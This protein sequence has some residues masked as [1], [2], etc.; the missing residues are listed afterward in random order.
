MSNAFLAGDYLLAAEG[1]VRKRM[2]ALK[3]DSAHC[4]AV[5][6]ALDKLGVDY[7]S[8]G[9]RGTAVAHIVIPSATLA[10]WLIRT[11]NSLARRQD[12]VKEWEEV[13]FL[14]SSI[15]SGAMERMIRMGTLRQQLAEAIAER[16]KKKKTR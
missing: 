3:V 15:T 6:E 16:K 13:G 2:M 8:P 4:R 1:A 12:H 7:E 5:R 9:W 11:S 14:G 10:L